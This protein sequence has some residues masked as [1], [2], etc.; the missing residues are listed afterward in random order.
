[1]STD[2]HVIRITF[3]PAFHPRNVLRR[4]QFVLVLHALAEKIVEN[5]V[6]AIDDGRVLVDE[7]DSGRFELSF[8]DR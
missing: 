2:E 3:T 8:F 6:I 1:M 7:K 5:G 4:A